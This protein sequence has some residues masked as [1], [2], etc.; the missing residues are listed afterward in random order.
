[1]GVQNIANRRK[2]I[3]RHHGA[4]D[5]R[6]AELDD[7]LRAEK[8]AAAIRKALDGAPPLSQAQRDRINALLDGR[9][10]AEA[11]AS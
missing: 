1:M 3:V 11:V 4:D 7:E 5:P 9:T 2:A 8:I 6:V 10:A